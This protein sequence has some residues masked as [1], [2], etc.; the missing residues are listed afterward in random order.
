MHVGGYV[1]KKSVQACVILFTYAPTSD[2][3]GLSK[4]RDVVSTNCSFKKKCVH[5]SHIESHRGLGHIPGLPTVPARAHQTGPTRLHAF[6]FLFYL[7]RLRN[8]FCE[9]P[10]CNG[11]IKYAVSRNHVRY[12][13]Q[14]RN[15]KSLRKPVVLRY[16][17]TGIWLPKDIYFKVFVWIPYV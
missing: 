11:P 9:A 10:N 8:T 3:I 13:F 2:L 4:R 7:F 15:A 5:M 14:K 1:T 12:S 17:V 6:L 16:D